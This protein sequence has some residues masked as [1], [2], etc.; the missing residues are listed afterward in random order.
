[1]KDLSLRVLDFFFFLCTTLKLG[2]VR[3]GGRNGK[4]AC[5]ENRHAFNHKELRNA[6]ST[7]CTR[8]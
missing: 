5:T 2:Y 4:S 3:L 6:F 1:M 8:F 7:P